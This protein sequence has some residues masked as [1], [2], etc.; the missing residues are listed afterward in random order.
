MEFRLNK[1]DTDIRKKLADE[2]KDDKVHAK[3]DKLIKNN[4]KNPF[5]EGN[6]DADEKES[7]SKRYITID[8]VIEK[9]KTIVI[10]AEKA[11]D[12]ALNTSSGM[13]I[14]KLK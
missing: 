14:D 5:V 11:E 6:I 8:G 3:R 12:T 4:T 7:S 9:K 1:I 10:E 13:F 2:V